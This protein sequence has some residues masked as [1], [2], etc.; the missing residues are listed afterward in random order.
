M[1]T[2]EATKAE[3]VEDPSPGQAF[4]RAL[5]DAVGA[6]ATALARKAGALV[7]R[8]DAVAD[9]G[10]V[11]EALTGLADEGLDA[12]AEAGGAAQRAVAEGVKAHLHGESPTRAAIRGAWQEGSPA[13][14]AAIVTGAVGAVVLLLLSPAL[15]LVYLLSWLVLAAVHRARPTRRPQPATA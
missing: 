8:L 1:T 6:V 9:K 14:R 3:P 7:D 10:R 4:G 2:T 12:V 15:L 5:E 11:T 13:V